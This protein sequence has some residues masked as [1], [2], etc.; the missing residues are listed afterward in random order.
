MIYFSLVSVPRA[1]PGNPCYAQ[2]PVGAKHYAVTG[3]PAVCIW[4]RQTRFTTFLM[5]LLSISSYVR[6][7]PACTLPCADHGMRH[8]EHTRP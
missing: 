3:L 4:C 5:N 2:A 6:Q 8:S 7:N 1:V